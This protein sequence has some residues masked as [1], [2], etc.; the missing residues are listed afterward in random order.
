MLEV[1]RSPLGLDM[2]DLSDY[3][4]DLEGERLKVTTQYIS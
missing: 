1:G 4:G 2:V 3:T